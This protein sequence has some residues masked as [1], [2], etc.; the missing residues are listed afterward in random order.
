[1]KTEGLEKANASQMSDQEWID[2]TGHTKE[3][4]ANLPKMSKETEDWTGSG[5][6]ET[7]DFDYDPEIYKNLLIRKQNVSGNEIPL[8]DA[9]KQYMFLQDSFGG[10]G[11]L[12]GSIN[13]IMKERAEKKLAGWS[14]K[15]VE[16]YRL[17]ELNDLPGYLNDR[18]D[19]MQILQEDNF[20]RD[21]PQIIEIQKETNKKLEEIKE[22]LSI[23]D[24]N[25]RIL[26]ENPNALN[27]QTYKGADTYLQAE[28][29]N[30]GFFKKTVHD[31]VTIQ[32]LTS[33]R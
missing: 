26:A 8:N 32:A 19:E 5:I 18:L 12:Q 17:Q 22:V 24:I 16:E 4:V 3:Y 25:E 21:L 2:K 1:M 27:V 30:M 20:G 9:E 7:A 23:K 33:S 10:V 11:E 31:D 15:E 6:L 13:Q 29:N 28:H 14:V